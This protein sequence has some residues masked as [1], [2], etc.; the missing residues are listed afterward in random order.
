LTRPPQQP[1]SYDR[2]EA[3]AEAPAWLKAIDFSNLVVNYHALKPKPGA[4]V[5]LSVNRSPLLVAG[6]F[7]K[8]KVIA[9]TGFTPGA[10]AKAKDPSQTI[11]DRVLLT[12]ADHLLFADIA[13]SILALASGDSPSL[14][15]AESLKMR[16][17]PVFETLKN[18]S[19]TTWPEVSWTWLPDEGS[20][21]RAKV[22]I[23]NASGYLRRFRLR[24]DGPDIE[25]GYV[26]PLW[27]N[28]YFDLLPGE[29]AEC[30]VEMRTAEK[31]PVSAM[32]LVGERLQAA[33]SRTYPVPAH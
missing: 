30:S 8:G 24:L 3:G 25:S 23:R 29:T 15:I 7:G 21:A 2:I 4:T 17:T 6:Q 13:S 26:L 20:F 11:L 33:E 5:L 27:S 22:T 14:P 16:T 28:Q 12:S 9:Y 1:V 10:S 18:R 31:R 32:V 19:A